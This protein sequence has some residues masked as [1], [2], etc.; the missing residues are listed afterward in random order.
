MEEDGYA[1][2]AQLYHDG[3]EENYKVNLCITSDGMV[4]LAGDGLPL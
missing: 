3:H 2:V 4:V 1:V